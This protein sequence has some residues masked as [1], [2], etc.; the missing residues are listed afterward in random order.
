MYEAERSSSYFS[1]SFTHYQAEQINKEYSMSKLCQKYTRLKGV[2]SIF[3][4]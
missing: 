1:N 4:G 3:N 2:E